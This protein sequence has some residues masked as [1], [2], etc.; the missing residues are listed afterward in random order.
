MF[1]IES[2]NPG[3]DYRYAMM[4]GASLMLGWTILL[5]W[6]DRAP[7]QRK[8][9]I[10][11]TTVPVMVGMTLDGVFA[12]STGLIRYQRMIPMWAIQAVLL[13]LSMYSYFATP[14]NSV[15]NGG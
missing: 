5:I 14:R 15:H 2:F 7:I 8:G 11:I 9:I 12:V 6:A 10:L 1:G 4:I 13:S 3:Y